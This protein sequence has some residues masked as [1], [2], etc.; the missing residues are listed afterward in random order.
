[1]GRRLEARCD[2]TVP[3]PDKSTLLGDRQPELSADG[4]VALGMYLH[5]VDGQLDLGSATATALGTPVGERQVASVAALP[6]SSRFAGR[7]AA[8]ERSPSA[9]GGARR[10]PTRI[11]AAPRICALMAV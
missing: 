6:M 1:V 10:L 11:P 8:I 4:G 2:G 9:S 7:F 3:K 5:P